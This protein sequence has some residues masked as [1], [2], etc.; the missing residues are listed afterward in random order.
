[1]KEAI[2]TDPR[3]AM[4]SGWS[5]LLA[6]LLA[7]LLSFFILLFSITPMNE[8]NW[9]AMTSALTRQLND[10]EAPP[11]VVKGQILPREL[12][13]TPGY[14]AQLLDER[15]GENRLLAQGHWA[16]VGDSLLV[17]LDKNTVLD[18]SGDDLGQLGSLLARLGNGLTI[19]VGEKDLQT[20]QANA[21]SIARDISAIKTPQHMR[22]LATRDTNFLLA[23]TNY[24][25]DARYKGAE[26]IA[27]IVEIRGE[28][29]KGRN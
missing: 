29:L 20:A 22:T 25:P 8:A 17:F 23:L 12:S 1:M 24:E 28:T 21:D 5:L 11:Q 2:D 9:A 13:L 14:V 10:I 16:V 27:I 18:G 15:R 6:D 3:V 19:V 26:D 4:T 7:L